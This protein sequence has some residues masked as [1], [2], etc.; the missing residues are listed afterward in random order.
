MALRL[1][2][3]R[4]ADGRTDVIAARNG[5]A[6]VVPGVAS[7]RALAMRAIADG[8]DLAGAV[9]ACGQGEPVDLAAEYAAGRLVAPIDHEDPAHMVLA[10]TGL[11]HLGSA[12]GRDKMHREAPAAETQTD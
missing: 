12:E 7:G 1:L 4:G 3:R 5:Q 9:A 2:Q 6:A 8:S 10:G 11:T